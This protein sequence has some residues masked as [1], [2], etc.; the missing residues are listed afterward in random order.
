MSTANAFLSLVHFQGRDMTLTKSDDS[1]TV[2]LKV[3]VSNYSRNLAGPEQISIDGQEFVMAKKD[4]ADFGI[5]A[6]G[7]YLFDP[8][9][10]ENTIT[11]VKHLLGLGG[12][13]IG[14]RV[15]TS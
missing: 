2:T 11:E 15:R 14:Y 9:L 12:D 6:R 1:K 4:L 3:A 5:P 10:D 8:E 13:I 7:D